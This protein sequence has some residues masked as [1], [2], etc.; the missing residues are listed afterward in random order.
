MILITE[1][2]NGWGWKGPLEIIW[3]NPL[4]KQVPLEEVVQDH[5]LVGFEYL[6]RRS[7]NLSGQ[8]ASVFSH[9]HRKEVLPHIRIC[10]TWPLFCHWAPLKSVWCIYKAKNKNDVLKERKLSILIM[11]E[12]QNLNIYENILVTTRKDHFDSKN[13][14]SLLLSCNLFFLLKISL[15]QHF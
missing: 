7:H 10:A 8:L 2:E 4:L 1:S 9:P 11:L 6:Q 13:I 14:C 15:K 3:S 12:F 5:V